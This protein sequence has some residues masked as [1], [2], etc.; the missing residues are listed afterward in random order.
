[1]LSD[2]DFSLSYCSGC[3]WIVYAAIATGAESIAR[4]HNGLSLD[5]DGARMQSTTR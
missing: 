1:M 3:K 5:K 4:L 2:K